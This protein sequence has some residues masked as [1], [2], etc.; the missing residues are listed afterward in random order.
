MLVFRML[1]QGGKSIESGIFSL[2]L[3]ELY[4]RVRNDVR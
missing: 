3:A 1:N 2:R 4:S